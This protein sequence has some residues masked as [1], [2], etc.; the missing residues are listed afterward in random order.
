MLLRLHDH[1][2]TITINAKFTN[3]AL[4]IESRAWERGYR[5]ASLIPTWCIAARGVV[6]ETCNIPVKVT[7]P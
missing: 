3:Q 2:H 1:A 4:Q 5:T 6:M 7:I